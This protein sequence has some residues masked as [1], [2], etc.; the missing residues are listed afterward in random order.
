MAPM[1]TNAAAGCPPRQ[2]TYTY[3]KDAGAF[4]GFLDDL[5]G[6]WTQ[7]KDLPELETML[8][9]LYALCDNEA[10]LASARTPD[11]DDRVPGEARQGTLQVPRRPAAPAG[12]PRAVA[13]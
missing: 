11:P 3:W 1:K 2:M 13:V 9:D 7:G 6:W 10:S 5:P 4:V 12:L 8:L